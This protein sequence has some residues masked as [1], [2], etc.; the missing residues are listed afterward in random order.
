MSTYRIVPETNLKKNTIS[1]LPKTDIRRC[2]RICNDTKDCIA[3]V[4]KKPSKLNPG[5]ICLLKN[6][7]DDSTVYDKN[8]TLYIKSGNPSYWQL[9]TFLAIVGVM[10]FVLFCKR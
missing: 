9:W 1:T 5:G 2:R 4:W 8:S 3:F 6:K 10:I 7:M